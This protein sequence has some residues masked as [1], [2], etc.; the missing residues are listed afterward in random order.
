[1]LGCYVCRVINMMINF[2]FNKLDSACKRCGEEKSTGKMSQ[3]Y[4]WGGKTAQERTLIFNTLINSFRL[5]PVKI[6]TIL[7]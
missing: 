5:I 7:L 3:D 1:M 4:I 2:P 6:I